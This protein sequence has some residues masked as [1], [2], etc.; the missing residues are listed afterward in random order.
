MK[1]HSSKLNA[2][3]YGTHTTK[4]GGVTTFTDT[5]TPSADWDVLTCGAIIRGDHRRANP[6]NYEV[7]RRWSGNLEAT[8]ETSSVRSSWFGHYTKIPENLYEIFSYEL[9]A[10]REQAY[11]NLLEQIRGGLDLSTDL[12][13]YKKTLATP[14][15]VGKATKGLVAAFKQAGTRKL[16]APMKA[17]GSAW[18]LFQY[19]VK[20]TLQTIHDGI[21]EFRNHCKSGFRHYTAKS[22]R[23]TPYQKVVPNWPDTAFWTANYTGKS[24]F[25][26]MYRVTLR[27][28]G[29]TLAQAARWSSLNPASIAWE[30]MP[31]SFAIDW[32]INVG[33]Y[34]REQE[35]SLIYRNYFDNG[36]VTYSYVIDSVLKSSRNVT[37]SSGIFT[38]SYDAFGYDRGMRRSVLGGLPSPPLPKVM[39]KLGS[40]RLLNAAALLS[41][42]LR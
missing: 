22:T 12:A 21:S 11:S 13:Q 39:P 5:V 10:V 7:A 9:D 20:P 24:R 8:H 37:N 28:Q 36:F 33:G 23:R 15:D 38:G 27:N 29:D 16:T 26:A 3:L 31:W 2:H 18:L 41:G 40:W 35:T 17:V 1:A 19:G 30:L 4:P 14:R 42:F 25:N 6:W 34:L 32:F